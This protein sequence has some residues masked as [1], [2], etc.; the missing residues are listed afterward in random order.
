MTTLPWCGALL[1]IGANPSWAPRAPAH[2][3]A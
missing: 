3:P 1:S 2:E